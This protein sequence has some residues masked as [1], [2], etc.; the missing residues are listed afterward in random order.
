MI[1]AV[2]HAS[3]SGGCR[4]Y[5]LLQEPCAAVLVD[6][7]SLEMSFAG[8]RLL[9]EVEECF[10]EVEATGAEGRQLAAHL[11]LLNQKYSMDAIVDVLRKVS[12]G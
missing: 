8:C 6:F 5:H 10:V 3:P 1:H 12:Q 4:E 11:R 7:G 9:A 2:A